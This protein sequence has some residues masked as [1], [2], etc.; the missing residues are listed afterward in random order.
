MMAPNM[1]RNMEVG[2]DWSVALVGPYTNPDDGYLIISPYDCQKWCTTKAAAE[3]EMILKTGVC[4]FEE[5]FEK[6]RGRGLGICRWSTAEIKF[7]E[8]QPTRS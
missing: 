1:M 8:Y 2:I 4:E 3:S 6:L 7:F 5:S